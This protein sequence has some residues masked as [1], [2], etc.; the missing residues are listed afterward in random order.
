MNAQLGDRRCCTAAAVIRVAVIESRLRTAAAMHGAAIR[1]CGTDS[2]AR[3]Q[4]WPGFSAAQTLA[5][6]AAL[7]VALLGSINGSR[8]VTTSYGVEEGAGVQ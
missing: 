1:V 4:S 8:A 7:T 5:A 2:P 3:M 6:Y